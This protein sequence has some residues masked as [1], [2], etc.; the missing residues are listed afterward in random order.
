MQCDHKV[1]PVQRVKEERG[2]IQGCLGPV[3]QKE[4]L[5]S[6]ECQ[7]HLDCWVQKEPQGLQ[8]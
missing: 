4:I 7:G 1:L 2:E 8:D 6:Q 3:D 5:V